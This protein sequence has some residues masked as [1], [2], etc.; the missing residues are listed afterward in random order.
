ML[1]ELIARDLLTAALS[2]LVAPG[3][4]VEVLG[5]QVSCKPN[6]ST[7]QIRDNEGYVLDRLA[8]PPH[9]RADADAALN[10]P[11]EPCAAPTVR[12]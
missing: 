11:E 10:P 5:M 3:E 4:T 7:L 1:T 6:G 8:V 2:R 9:I 12:G